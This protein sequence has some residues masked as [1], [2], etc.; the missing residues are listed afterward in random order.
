M[1]NDYNRVALLY[2]Y[3]TA[4]NA[5]TTNDV[6]FYVEE[7]QKAG[8]PVLEL[9][10]G[11]GRVLIP[12]AESGVQITGLDYSTEMLAVAQNKVNQ[13]AP[14]VQNRIQLVQG[15]MRDFELS[16]RFHLIFIPFR[17]FLHL[18]T[19]EDQRAALLNI[20]KHLTEN[21]RLILG[22]FD[23]S[24]HIISEHFGSL[25][26]AVKRLG[27]FTYP[28]TGREYLLW[29]SRQYHPQEQTVDEYF[30]FEELDE[31]GRVVSKQYFALKLR[32]AYRYEM[33]YLLEL[34]G[35]TIDALYGDFQRGP[36]RYAAE[37][38][39]VL[40]KSSG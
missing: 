11:T 22:L 38:I 26:S 9:A 40:R 19:P 34:C 14:E 10:C 7:A 23:P 8:S 16:Q 20:R 3:F 28:E 30:I 32:Y 12:I 5:V 39:W 2:D 29:S 1:D 21:G 37:Q 4:E 24:L 35:Y 17:S 25:G 15:D 27:K 33:Q 31:A 18:Q 36:F 6:P 13:R